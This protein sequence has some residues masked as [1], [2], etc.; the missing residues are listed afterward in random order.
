M[1]EE[2]SI[3]LPEEF[4][5]GPWITGQQVMEWFDISKDNL[6]TWRHRGIIAFSGMGSTIMYNKPWI[7]WQLTQNW[8]WKRPKE[9]K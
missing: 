4:K 1:I 8:K 9:D 3:V 7:L 5:D 6:K 2:C